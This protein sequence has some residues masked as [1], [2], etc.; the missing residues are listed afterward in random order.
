MFQRIGNAGEKAAYEYLIEEYKK[1]EYFQKENENDLNFIKLYRKN[2]ND[3]VEIKLCNTFIYKQPGYDIEII[4]QEN[5]QKITK[6]VEVKTHTIN[7]ILNG[8]IKLSYEQ[9]CLSR[10]NKDYIVIVMKAFFSGNEIKCE[11]NKKFDPFYSYEGKEV[12]PEQR[13]YIFEFDE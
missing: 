7:S 4:I 8:K 12:R 11:L 5:G 6:Y 3:F 13:E 10:G 1:K 9:Y 2:C